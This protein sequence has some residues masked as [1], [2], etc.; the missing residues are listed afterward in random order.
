MIEEINE[1]EFNEEVLEAST[2][3]L[4]I[5]D[6]Y[7]DWCPPC[8]MLHPVLQKISEEFKDK[9][10]ILR[11]DVDKNPF[12]AQ[13]Y[14]ISAIPSIKIFKNKNIVSEFLGFKTYEEVKEIID[15]VLKNE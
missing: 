7:A 11:V 14:N 13:K 8:K 10:K 5:L 2:Q 1:Q 15:S 4:I 3:K 6:F 9:I 12:L